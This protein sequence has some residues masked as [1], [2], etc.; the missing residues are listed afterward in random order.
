MDSLNTL[1]ALG[2]SYTI[3]EAVDKGDSFPMQ[4]IRRLREK[5]IVFAPP[6]VIAATGWTT[7]DLIKALDLEAIKDTYSFVTVLAGVNNQYQHRSLSEYKT[8]FSVLLHHAI[9]C[10]GGIKNQVIVL[11]IPD[12][13]VT[14]FAENLNK[15]IISKEID[16]FN[17]ANKTIALEAGVHYLDIISISRSAKNEPS[18]IASDGLHPSAKMY[19]EWSL[20]LS[21][22]IMQEI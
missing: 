4:T 2:D 3:G 9:S 12:Y 18:L 14:P 16:E 5:N 15:D 1:L 17:N 7:A 22:C 21:E 11:S 10:G 6:K 8:E 19:A 20:L 13:S